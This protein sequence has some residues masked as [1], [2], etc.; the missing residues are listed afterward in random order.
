MVA[1]GEG[2]PDLNK[3]RKD[4]AA[5]QNRNAASPN[6]SLVVNKINH[7]N[8][9]LTASQQT[10]VHIT[11]WSDMFLRSQCFDIKDPEAS[12]NIFGKLCA[13][14]NVVGSVNVERSGQ[15]FHEA[16][17]NFAWGG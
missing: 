10:K 13:P 4:R 17:R 12:K 16:S 5:E 14:P 3:C 6:G 7:E 8:G 15:P 1:S 11:P 2:I 9:K